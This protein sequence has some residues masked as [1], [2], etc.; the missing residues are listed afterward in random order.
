MSEPSRSLKRAPQVAQAIRAILQH[1]RRMA[2]YLPIRS[3]IDRLPA[4]K[5]LKSAQLGFGQAKKD[6]G[7]S[8]KGWLSRWWMCFLA[9]ADLLAENRYLS[10]CST[11]R[12][13]TGNSSTKKPL[14]L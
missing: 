3:A 11:L 1:S 9:I 14:Q 2:F 6:K 4:A 13:S 5:Q 7:C 10:S 8:A 12:L